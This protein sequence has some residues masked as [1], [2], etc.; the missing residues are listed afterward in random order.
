MRGQ[1][2]CT[3]KSFGSVLKLVDQRTGPMLSHKLVPL[4]F[5]VFTWA[6]VA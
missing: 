5:S 2:L 4:I 1:N 3:V 6:I